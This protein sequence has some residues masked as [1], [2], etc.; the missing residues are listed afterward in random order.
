M[1]LIITEDAIGNRLAPTK[2]IPAAAMQDN[3]GMVEIE[4]APSKNISG[5]VD[6]EQVTKNAPEVLE[7]MDKEIQYPLPTHN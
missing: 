2:S 6:K 3:D 4:E 7:P 1:D 5:L